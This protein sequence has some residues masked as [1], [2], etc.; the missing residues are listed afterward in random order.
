MTNPQRYKRLLSHCLLCGLLLSR[1]TLLAQSTITVV[2]NSPQPFTNT[3]VEIPWNTVLLAFP[4]VDTARLRV[5]LLP[6]NRELPYQ[7]EHRGQQAVRHLLVQVSV[8]SQ[9]RIQLRLLPE[10]PAPVM[11]RTFCRYVPERFDDFAW[12]NDRIAFRIYG[13]A[14]NGR[15]DNAFGTDVWA[16]RTDKLVLNNW[17]KTGDY[18]GDHGEGLDYYHVG[19]TLGAGDIGA[20]LG[21][22][23]NY[24][25]NYTAW[26]VL[27]NGPLRSTFRV[28]YPAYAF[29]G[30]KVNTTKI[31]SLDAGSQLSRVEVQVTHNHPRPLPMVVGISLRPEPNVARPNAARQGV[32]RF[33]EKKGIMSYWEPTHGADGTLGIGTVFPAPTA[34]VAM[35]EQQQHA[36]TEVL[37]ESGKSFVYHD[38]A[39][40]DKAGP[41]SAGQ[42]T[43][44]AAWQSHLQEY[45]DRLRHPLI[46]ATKSGR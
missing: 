46:I 38:G 42:I 21:D 28:T 2:N 10:P 37:V 19:L 44:A 24:I 31:I 25:H 36:L 20:W 3:I 39:A 35:R 17:Y 30:T 14:L 29:G 15:K 1:H 22:T 40:W 18:H 13:K 45:A 6:N 7:L 43:S 5:V 4:A 27:D 23:I 33:E 32:V 11:P 9:Q 34:L 8:G 41:R 12:E 16:K 26:Q